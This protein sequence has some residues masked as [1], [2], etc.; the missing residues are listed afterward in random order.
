MIF[1]QVSLELK[2]SKRLQLAQIRRDT[3]DLG[4]ELLLET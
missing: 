1:I 3:G 4:G 2:L